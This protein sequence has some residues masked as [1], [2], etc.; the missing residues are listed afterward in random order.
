[1]FMCWVRGDV[2]TFCSPVLLPSIPRFWDRVASGL[3]WNIYRGVIGEVNISPSSHKFQWCFIQRAKCCVLL[4]Y[5]GLAHE[6]SHAKLCSAGTGSCW[7]SRE[8]TGLERE[9][10]IQISRAKECTSWSLKLTETK[11]NVEIWVWCW[12][13]KHSSTAGVWSVVALAGGGAQWVFLSNHVYCK[14]NP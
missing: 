9:R 14:R 11:G 5:P 1:M 7:L 8:W 6:Q 12:E 13:L 10:R 2:A 3:V 4:D